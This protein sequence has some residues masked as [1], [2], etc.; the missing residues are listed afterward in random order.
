MQDA[1]ARAKDSP[2]KPAAHNVQALAAP[3]LYDPAGHAAA[4]AFVLPGGHT[5]P[6]LQPPEQDGTD[7]PVLAPNVPAG[8]N[9][10]HAEEFRPVWEP[11]VPAGQ[12]KHDSAP[13]VLYVP[14]AQIN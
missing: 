8:H 5:Y 12:G 7:S 13:P 9:A 10:V 3:R 4:V 2:Y 14:T 6:G 1:L 11:Y